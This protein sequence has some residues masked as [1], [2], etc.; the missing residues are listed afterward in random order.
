MGPRAVR[1]SVPVGLLPAETEPDKV[2]S[3]ADSHEHANQ[4][5]DFL[6]QPLI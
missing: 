1:L 4:G 2:D 3:A 5:E 6:I